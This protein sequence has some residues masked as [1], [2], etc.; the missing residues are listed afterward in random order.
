MTN[1]LS[2]ARAPTDKDALARSERRSGRVTGGRGRLHKIGVG[3]RAQVNIGERTAQP[4]NR[5]LAAH[6][7]Q[8]LEQWQAYNPAFRVA[9]AID[10]QIDQRIIRIM[11]MFLL[12]YRQEQRAR[13]KELNPTPIGWESNRQRIPQ[14]LLP[15]MTV[16]VRL[17][18]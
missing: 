2:A 17:K 9:C 14:V 16:I 1:I 12:G 11:N 10:D 4:A 6:G 13:L 15:V 8:R 5:H 3:C 7:Q 18:E